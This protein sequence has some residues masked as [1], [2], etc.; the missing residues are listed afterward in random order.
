MS[1]IT[2]KIEIQETSLCFLFDFGVFQYINASSKQH[3]IVA[4]KTKF[5]EEYKMKSLLG[6]ASLQTKLFRP[7]TDT[8]P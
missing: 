1:N 4:S 5:F 3:H 2:R 7:L 6:N 8:F